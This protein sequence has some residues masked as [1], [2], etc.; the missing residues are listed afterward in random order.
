MGGRNKKGAAGT[1]DQGSNSIAN[2]ARRALELI[3]ATITNARW[4]PSET[5]VIIR[6]H[7]RGSVAGA[8][9][10]T[11]LKTRFA[12]LQVEVTL[13][14]PVPGPSQPDH[15]RTRNL[16]GMT[17]STVVYAI[18]SGYNETVAAFRPMV[19]RGVK[20]IIISAQKHSA[21]LVHGFRYGDRIYKGSRLND[22]EPGLYVDP[23]TGEGGADERD[24]FPL[25]RFRDLTPASIETAIALAKMRSTAKAGDL[26]RPT[27]IRKALAAMQ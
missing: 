4:E 25:I 8:L 13:F 16:A 17:E 21:G 7:S 11:R 22:L 27:N 10:A 15:Y 20:R 18:R 1:W 23:S 2:V 9:L 5:R 14:D 6:A 24:A 12:N 19:A 26:M 3:D